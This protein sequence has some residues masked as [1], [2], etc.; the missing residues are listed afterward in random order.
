[1]ARIPP[2]LYILFGV[3]AIVAG[4]LGVGHAPAGLPKVFWAVVTVAG[5]A[6]LASS[7]IV[8]RRPRRQRI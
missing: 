7:W 2:W 1:M 4:V 8:V 3:I 5:V 6:S